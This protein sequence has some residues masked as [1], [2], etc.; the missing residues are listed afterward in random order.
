MAISSWRTGPLH[1]TQAGVYEALTSRRP[2]KISVLACGARWGKDRLCIY[3]L[4]HWATR[5]ATVE[6]ERRQRERLIPRVL[7]WYVAPTFALL[8]Q[9]WD[10]ITEFA[11]EVP[12]VKFNRAELRVYLPGDVQI[13]FKSADRPGSLLSRG[14]D[15]VVCTEAARTKRDAW[16]NAILTRLASPGR[17]PW[18]RGG[19]A[20]LNSTPN[21]KIGFTSSG[22]GRAQI[23]LAICGPGVFRRMITLASSAACS[24]RSGS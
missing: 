6:R 24:M 9:A 19:L 16:E 23:P 14:L 18:G 11:G 21:G 7:C 13:E 2:P 17:G 22:A 8:R 4:L 12:G 5:M 1:P 20:I 10:E 15:L 3:L